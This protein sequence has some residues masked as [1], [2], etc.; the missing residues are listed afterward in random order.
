MI[1]ED[2]HPG[3]APGAVLD[4]VRFALERLDLGLPPGHVIDVRPARSGSCTLVI[5][6]HG[7]AIATIE[8]P[9]FMM[10]SVLLLHAQHNR[11]ARATEP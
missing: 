11:M 7:G 1:T 2:P 4:A 9:S 6:K 8:L 10:A 3:V 5:E